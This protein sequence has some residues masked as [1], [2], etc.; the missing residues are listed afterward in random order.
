MR[1]VLAA[2]LLLGL[3]TTPCLAGGDP[4]PVECVAGDEVEA[5]PCGA[6]G[7]PCGGSN[8]YRLAIE[9]TDECTLGDDG[10]VDV[11]DLT[12]IILGWGPCS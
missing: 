11:R 8:T 2:F 12:D 9:C 7:F 4:C 6:D 10:V 5:E 3:L 1:P